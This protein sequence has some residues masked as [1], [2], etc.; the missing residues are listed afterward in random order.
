MTSPYKNDMNI[1][2]SHIRGTEKGPGY[3]QI[4]RKK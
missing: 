3:K 2:A 4:E 1:I